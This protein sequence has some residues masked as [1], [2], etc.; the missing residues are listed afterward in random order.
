MRNERGVGF[1]HP[2]TGRR[3]QLG[4]ALLPIG[5]TRRSPRVQ[6]DEEEIGPG[7]EPP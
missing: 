7:R 3:A 1:Y 6:G 5:G 2:G 4:V